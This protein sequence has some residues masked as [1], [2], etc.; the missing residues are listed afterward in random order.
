MN[1]QQFEQWCRGQV[2]LPAAPAY[3][4]KPLIMA[5]LNVTPDSFSD[6]GQFI[7]TNQ[8]FRHAMTMI[9]QGADIIDIGGES[10]RPGAEA[11]SEDE[12]LARVIPVIERIRAESDVCISIDTCKATV[13]REAVL[14]GASLIND[15]TAL[16]GI[17]A[18]TTAVR[19]K[20]PVCL[21]HMHGTPKSM[22]HAPVYHQPILAEINEFFQ[23]RIDACLQAGMAREHILLDPGF[24]FGKSVQHNMYLIKQLSAFRKHQQ[25]LLL[26]VSRKSTI[27]AVLNKPIAERL[28]G[29][30]AIAIV[31]ALQGIS[32]IRTHDVEE[33]RQ[34]LE[35][36]DT[37][38]KARE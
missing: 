35:M 29:G 31:A 13:M 34:A 32:I 6:G 7:G 36:L 24:G 1:S 19:L 12:E 16:R 2:H 8:A 17:N 30:I 4:H 27:G 18:L 28:I 38:Q 25:P 14:T 33:T 37:I 22:Q 20:V 3:L 26:G 9:E 15:I 23:Q 11:I 5:I 10:S 21:M